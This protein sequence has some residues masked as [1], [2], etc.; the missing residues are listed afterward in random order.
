[1]TAELVVVNRK[2]RRAIPD[3][4]RA[5]LDTRLRWLWHQRFGTVQMV[6]QHTD[7][8]LDKTACTLVLQ[9]IM[10]RDLDSIAQL[11]HRIEGGAIGDRELLERVEQSIRI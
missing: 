8:I 7:D 10:A 5:S 1:V 3:A 11:L 9:A 6:W 2:F 4:H